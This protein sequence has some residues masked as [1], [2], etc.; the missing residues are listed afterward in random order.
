[1]RSKHVAVLPVLTFLFKKLADSMPCIENLFQV[2]EIAA[3][4]GQVAQAGTQRARM[5]YNGYSFSL[6]R[7]QVHTMLPDK[8]VRTPEDSVGS[9]GN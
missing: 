7:S 5:C 1:M 9:R 6:H 4:P 3:T 8:Q 2:L